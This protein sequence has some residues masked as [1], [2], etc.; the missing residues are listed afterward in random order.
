M[1]AHELT[2]YK[3]FWVRAGNRPDTYLVDNLEE[4]K[5]LEL[6]ARDI[7]LDL[8]GCIG[9][10]V[11]WAMRHGVKRIISIEP[12]PTNFALLNKN[13][14]AEREEPN[15]LS[16]AEVIVM[17]GAVVP[18]RLAKEHQ[19][20]TLYQAKASWKHSLVPTRG[21]QKIDVPA[22]G[23]GQLFR[24]FKPTKLKIDVEGSEYD[25][26]MDSEAVIP[27]SVKGMIMELHLTR[28][29]ELEKAKALHQ[30]FL[31]LGF[32]ATKSPNLSGRGWM[33]LACY[34]R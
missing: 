28:D 8:G 9:T 32:A 29:G 1:V 25:I 17:Q 12:D 6:N 2:R 14:E 24:H 13:L 33:T 26:L 31:D 7:V 27:K 4:Y 11:V 15:Q 20:V 23:I 5:R 18:T 30:H 34:E 21:R 19:K 22:I 16:Q 10:F 3:G